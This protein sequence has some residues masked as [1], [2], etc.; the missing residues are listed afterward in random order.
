MYA[1]TKRRQAARF[2]LLC[3]LI[4]APAVAKAKKAVVIPLVS[5]ASGVSD[6]VCDAGESVIGFKDNIPVCSPD[7]TSCK[8]AESDSRSIGSD[9]ADYFA[10]PI[11]TTLG[12]TPIVIGSAGGAPESGG[13]SDMNFSPLSGDNTAEIDGD[14]YQIII[15]VI[16]IGGLCPK[17]YQD[18]HP[19]WNDGIY[20]Y[21][22]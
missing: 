9:L 6:F 4:V 16:D 17:E 1:D 5:K 18:M 20:T 14:L 10:V 7:T 13:V 8:A 21:N 12:V 2:F 22:L 11:H 3:L 15:R 19:D